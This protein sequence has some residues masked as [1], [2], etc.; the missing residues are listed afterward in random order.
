V[1]LPATLVVAVVAIAA[2]A[3]MHS[4]SLPIWI[5]VVASV[6]LQVGYFVG[7]VVQYGVRVVSSR[8]GCQGLRR[9]RYRIP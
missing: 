4:A 8:R 9:S 3:K 6:S 1:L 2:V 5:T 7:V